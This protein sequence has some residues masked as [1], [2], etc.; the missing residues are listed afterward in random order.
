M[1]RFEDSPGLFGIGVGISTN[2]EEHC[3]FCGDIHN[4]GCD[5]ENG[6][7]GESVRTANFA[8]KQ[9]CDCCFERIE[10]AVLSRMPDILKWYQRLVNARRKAVDDAQKLID[11]TK[12]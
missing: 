8:G 5:P 6:N 1:S 10:N 2:Y 12:D 3:D 4:E 11:V 9:I 7:E